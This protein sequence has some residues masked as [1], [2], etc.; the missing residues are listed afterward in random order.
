[1]TQL[2]TTEDW[3]AHR[4]EMLATLPA[5]LQGESLPAV[6]LPYQRELLAATSKT[7]LVVV[8]KSRRIG[9]TWGIGA[10]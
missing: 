1:M 3:A 5:P 6:L 4:R 8:D 2:V 7:Q 9:A 10:D